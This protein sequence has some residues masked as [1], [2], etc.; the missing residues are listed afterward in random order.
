MTRPAVNPWREAIERAQVEG[1]G[2]LNLDLVR[3]SDLPRLRAAASAGDADAADLLRIAANALRRIPGNLIAEAEQCAA[4]A[5]ALPPRQHVIA[6]IR[7]ATDDPQSSAVLALALCPRCDAAP[8][9]AGAAATAVV[10]L[11]V[12]NLR[13]IRTTHPTGGRA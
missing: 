2:L 1:G 7:G 4:C 13:P 5:A 6:I 8:G 10:R 9:A 3:R 12:P 11:G